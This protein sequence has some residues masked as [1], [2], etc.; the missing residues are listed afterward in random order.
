MEDADNFE[1]KNFSNKHYRIKQSVEETSQSSIYR[2][3]FPEVMVF[4]LRPE[5]RKEPVMQNCQM[6]NFEA[7]KVTW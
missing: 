1:N 6:K 3:D 2:K 4:G 5:N 7:G